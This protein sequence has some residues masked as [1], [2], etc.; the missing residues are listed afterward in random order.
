MKVK[1]K[2]NTIFRLNLKMSIDVDKRPVQENGIQERENIGT[3]SNIYVYIV[4]ESCKP[5]SICDDF[6]SRLTG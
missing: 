4:H 1:D 5:T 6:N 2:L 3:A